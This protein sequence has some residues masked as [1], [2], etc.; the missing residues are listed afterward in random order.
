M[1]KCTSAQISIPKCNLSFTIFIQLGG[2]D[3]NGRNGSRVTL[4]T[5]TMVG[6]T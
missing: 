1:R 5:A 6:L 3:G 4:H 2:G